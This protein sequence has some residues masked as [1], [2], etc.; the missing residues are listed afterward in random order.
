LQT[1]RCC[2]RRAAKSS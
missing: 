1:H 2:H